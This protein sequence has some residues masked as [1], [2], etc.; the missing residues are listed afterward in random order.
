M[1]TTLTRYKNNENQASL[2]F[3]FDVFTN[4]VDF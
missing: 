3:D 2:L 1:E 4:L